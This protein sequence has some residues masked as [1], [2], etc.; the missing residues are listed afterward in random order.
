LVGRYSAVQNYINSYYSIAEQISP[1]IAIF[2]MLLAV[3]NK[4][5][6]FLSCVLRFCVPEWSIADVKKACKMQGHEDNGDNG[7]QTMFGAK[8]K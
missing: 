4:I 3:R 1:S 8:G 5:K 2:G 7:A 6:L